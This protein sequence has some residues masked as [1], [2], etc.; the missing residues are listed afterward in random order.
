MEAQSSIDDLIERHDSDPQAVA[1]RLRE[2]DSVPRQDLAAFSWLVNHVIGE[3]GLAWS[4]A[5]GLLRRFVSSNAP[6]SALLNFAACAY[7]AG[8]PVK[9]MELEWQI[10]RNLDCDPAHAR[11]A[12]QL[13]IL[14][15]AGP[16]VEPDDFAVAFSQCLARIEEG[17]IPEKLVEFY[18]ASLN[19]VTS[20]LLDHKGADHRREP[21]RSAL[22]TG[23]KLCGVMWR[24]VGTW[25]QY[26]RSDYLVALCANKV[27]D[28]D[29]ARKAAVSGVATIDA[30]GSEDVDRAFLLLELA[31]AE[32]ALG[33]TEK[34]RL[35]RLKALELAESF[36]PKLRQWFDSRATE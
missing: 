34:Q 28:W 13:R 31:R 30:N 25:I 36:D 12:V 14:Q 18:A 10:A 24:R 33:Q 19:N 2:F 11:C 9:G 6:T 1:D 4:D 29:D 22:L 5:L 7:L 16:A 27:G 17:A 21:I 26:E 8:E 15:H 32:G 3:E 35:A 23:S 20:K